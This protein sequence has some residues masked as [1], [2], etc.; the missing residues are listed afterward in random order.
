MTCQQDKALIH[1][2][3]SHVES[4]EDHVIHQ[5]FQFIK[6]GFMNHFV[7]VR[8]ID[9]HIWDM[10]RYRRFKARKWPSKKPIG[11]AKFS[12]ETSN[13]ERN[14]SSVR[15][16][17]PTD[18]ANRLEP[19]QELDPFT[20]S[21]LKRST[22]INPVHVKAHFQENFDND[23]HNQQSTKSSDE[24]RGNSGHQHTK[25]INNGHPDDIIGLY[26]RGQTDLPYDPRDMRGQNSKE[27]MSSHR[28]PATG[29]R[30]MR[31][32]SQ[33]N[34]QEDASVQL[35]KGQGIQLPGT[36]GYGAQHQQTR[37]AP[38]RAL[39]L[40]ENN[41]SGSFTPQPRLDGGRLGGFGGQ[42]GAWG[43]GP[44]MKRS[45]TSYV[46][47]TSHVEHFASPQYR[48]QQS[49]AGDSGL[50]P[51]RPLPAAS[52]IQ[53]RPQPGASGHNHFAAPPQ[54]PQLDGRPP[55][56]LAFDDEDL[57]VFLD[58][59]YKILEKKDMQMNGTL[60][61]DD[62]MVQDLNTLNKLLKAR[63]H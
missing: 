62:S 10:K 18:P 63:P 27:N 57:S 17:Q 47:G 3:A 4:R 14:K 50:L 41:H 44:G 24:I 28:S 53:L 34:F 22:R 5:A 51:G 9:S 16:N 59:R 45:D 52:G 48:R 19:D 8:K 12:K 55:R 31:T 11:G 36:Q 40:K 58:E 26:N 32:N 43:P 61:L 38:G 35:Q 2:Q 15:T 49:A 37:A 25:T 60:N 39:Q 56:E 1:S 7:Q 54:P 29:N 42:A 30:M 23:P 13:H 33:A 21:A 46:P 20:P 6:K